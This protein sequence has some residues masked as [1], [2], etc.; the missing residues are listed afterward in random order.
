M[1]K[2]Y[3]TMTDVIENGF[4]LDPMFITASH[5][6]GRYLYLHAV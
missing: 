2:M 6:T 4:E 3:T 1:S 5:V